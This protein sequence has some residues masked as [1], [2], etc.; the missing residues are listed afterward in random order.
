M[1]LRTVLYVIAE[2][3]FLPAMIGLVCLYVLLFAPAGAGWPR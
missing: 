1:N 2:A 3:L